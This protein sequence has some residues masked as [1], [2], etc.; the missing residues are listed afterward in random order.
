MLRRFNNVHN[1]FVGDLRAHIERLSP[2]ILRRHGIKYTYIYVCA[3]VCMLHTHI[4]LFTQR[5]IRGGPVI[6]TTSLH[7]AHLPLAVLRLPITKAHPYQRLTASASRPLVL[8]FRL[9]RPDG[10]LVCSAR[11]TRPRYDDPRFETL[12]EA[13]SIAI[14][15]ADPCL[16]F[17]LNDRASVRAHYPPSFLRALATCLPFCLLVFSCSGFRTCPSSRRRTDVSFRARI[18]D[19]YRLRGSI[20]RSLFRLDGLLS[21]FRC[22]TV[23]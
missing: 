9:P 12:T 2:F 23:T 17:G 13:L 21:R 6:A 18:L 5:D 4:H 19:E 22:Y 15:R 11:D 10:W 1:P 7:V 20:A 8:P 16:L 14:E 3:C